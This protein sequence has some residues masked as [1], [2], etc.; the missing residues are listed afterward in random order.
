MPLHFLQGGGADVYVRA[1]WFHE[2]ASG[3]GGTLAPPT[4]STIVLDAWAG[5]VDALVSELPGAGG[6]PQY[7][8]ALT[9][10]G[11]PITATLAA[12]GAYVLSGTPATYPV[13]VIFSYR[14]LGSAFDYSKSLDTV[15]IEPSTYVEKRVD[16]AGSYSTITNDGTAAALFQYYAGTSS[17]AQV[18]LAGGGV[19]LTADSAEVNI[20]A[21]V[22][23]ILNGTILGQY[24]T[25][26][27]HTAANGA[28][29]TINYALGNW[30]KITCDSGA[31]FTI[32]FSNLPSG[33][34]GSALTLEIVAGAVVPTITWTDKPADVTAPT[35]T[36][37]STHLVEVVNSGGSAK[38]IPIATGIKWLTA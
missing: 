5:G 30:H 13:A 37:S 35:Y 10:A 2:V 6:L 23:R 34:M 16:S 29:I 15:V 31:A 8:T 38:V 14:C 27:D 18:V 12:D 20:S 11:V 22:T 28:T 24:D 25:R 17:S 32:A 33:V 4:G 9:A 3:T 19:E 36:A 21:L 1:N 7:T 26:T